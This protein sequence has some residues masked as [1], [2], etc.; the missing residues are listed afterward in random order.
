MTVSATQNAGRGAMQGR[1][2]I[3]D[4]NKD[5][6]DALCKPFEPWGF[7]VMHASTPE[8]ALPVIAE[9]MKQAYP[10]DFVGVF[11]CKFTQGYYFTELSAPY[12]LEAYCSSP[13]QPLSRKAR[14]TR[15][16]KRHDGLGKMHTLPAA[17]ALHPPDQPLDRTP[18]PAKHRPYLPA[19]VR[20]R[21]GALS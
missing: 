17:R 9:G 18:R 6:R 16:R 12:D 4:D 10:L 5:V 15:Q 2:P 13:A 19:S 3:V 14:G 11:G 1:I 7:A 8:K 20:S 21:T